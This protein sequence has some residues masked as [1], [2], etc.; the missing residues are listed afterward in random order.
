MISYAA[1]VVNDVV[2]VVTVVAVVVVVA[3]I[4][5]SKCSL[6]HCLL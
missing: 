6:Y 1:V 3:D 2:T 4:T 5:L